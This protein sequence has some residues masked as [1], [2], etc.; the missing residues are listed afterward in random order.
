[1]CLRLVLRTRPPQSIP[2][3]AKRPSSSLILSARERGASEAIANG[4]QSAGDAPEITG[5]GECC[6][7][8]KLAARGCKKSPSRNFE[9]WPKF[10]RFFEGFFPNCP[11]R[12]ANASMAHAHRKVHLWTDAH[13]MRTNSLTTWTGPHPPDR[14]FKYNDDRPKSLPMVLLDTAGHRQ[15][16]ANQRCAIEWSKPRHSKRHDGVIKHLQMRMERAG[17]EDYRQVRARGWSA[18]N[19]CSMSA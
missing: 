15:H 7:C 5:T 13:L 4:V 19:Y 8:P 18:T 10:R 1:M 17:P 9:K 14:P 6:F 3:F 11:A 16:P 12:A 2:L